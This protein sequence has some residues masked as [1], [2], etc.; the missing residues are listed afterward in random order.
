MSKSLQSPVGVTFT[1]KMETD[2]A[3]IVEDLQIMGK[4]YISSTNLP[5]MY[6]DNAKTDKNGVTTADVESQFIAQRY[7]E[8]YSEDAKIN[9]QKLLSKKFS[10]AEVEA[11][12]W[13]QLTNTRLQRHESKAGVFHHLQLYQFN[14]G[15]ST[16]NRTTNMINK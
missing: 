5:K 2:K 10:S 4:P 7:D 11:M 9:A 6:V 12:P 1:I 13:D 8:L 16:M 14:K 3:F 15:D